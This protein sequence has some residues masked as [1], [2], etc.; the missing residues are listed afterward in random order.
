MERMKGKFFAALL[1]CLMVALLAAPALAERYVVVGRLAPIFEEAGKVQPAPQGG[2]QIVNEEEVEV[3]GMLAYGD[4]VDG[5][6][7][8]ERAGWV[9]LTMGPDDEEALGFVEL[10][11]LAPMPDHE[12][13]KARPWQVERDGLVPHL[14]PGS[15]PTSEYSSFVLPRGIVVTGEGQTKDAAGK[16][17][18]LCSFTTGYFHDRD[19]NGPETE[20]EDVDEGGYGIVVAGSDRRMAWLPQ[21]DLTDL[22]ASKPDLSKVEEKN[23]PASLEEDARK[24]MLKNGFYADPTPLLPED[25][26]QEDDM[27]DLYYDIDE[28]TPRFIAADLPLHAFH[29]YFDRALQKVEEK[30]LLPRTAEL[31][32]AMQEALNETPEASSDLERRA[33]A[34][35]SDFLS[36][37]QHLLTDGGPDLSDVAR[38]FAA[39]VLAGEGAG[40]SPFTEAPQ[41][42][43]LFVPRGHYTLNDDLKRY[44]RAT[45]LLGTPWPL[46]TET[47]AAATLILNSI[48]SQP[49]VR[50]KQEALYGP[51]TYL[52][53][54]A[55]VNSPEGVSEALRPFELA[56]LGDAAKVEALMKALDDAGKASAIQK[57][58]GKKFA[59]L[60]RR[61]T[62]DALIFHTLTWPD[63][64]AD[65]DK[66]GLPDPLDV[67]AVLGS[68]EA[69]REVERYEK[70]KGY[71]ENLKKMADLWPTW[72][73]SR[74]GQ[75]VYTDILEMFR[76]YIASK[77]SQQYFAKTPAWGYKK[78]L[79]AEAAM[80]ELK[81]DTILYGEQSGAEMGDGGDTWVAGPFDLPIP[82]GYVEPVPELYAALAKAARRMAELLEPMFPDEDYEHY[83][84]AFSEFAESMDELAG[85]AA[86]AREDRMTY[87]DFETILSLRLPS[88]LPEGFYEIYDEKGQDMLKMALVADVATDHEMT[89]QV[90]YMGVGAPRKLHVYVHDKSGGYRVTEGYMFS[91][92]TFTRPTLERRMDDE[93]WKEMVYDPARQGELKKLL[94]Y[95]HDRMYQ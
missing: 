90:L 95:W 4:V 60:P 58:A 53:G 16:S 57:L 6:P 63:T 32:T 45:Y 10:A 47:G 78:L 27:A 80:T 87:E 76:E 36:V 7:A 71:E 82:R 23:L 28:D 30:V 37:A 2:W 86:R 68:A 41:D 5:A 18:I 31:L 89:G 21:E 85:I 73:S 59:V 65:D 81:H 84:N 26:I 75:N 88:V 12:A 22:E 11:L 38:D 42:F 70:F 40:E 29:L 62:F 72:R 51:M 66:R 94:P 55:N 50:Q 48:L 74:D 67:M 19:G 9:S 20:G 35:V 8:K 3:T 1:A 46:D 33:R 49:D 77:G 34:N 93:Q 15:R 39:M 43:S 69:R 92:Y 91:Y 56:D 54:G 83:K 64:G 25:A 17:W 52:V 61:I 79:T 44:F 14:L 13:F 24:F